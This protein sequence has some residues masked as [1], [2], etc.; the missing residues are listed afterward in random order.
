MIYRTHTTWKYRVL[1]GR[2]AA[3]RNGRRWNDGM[4]YWQIVLV[5]WV[6]TMIY[7]YAL[8]LFP[9]ESALRSVPKRTLTRP[10]WPRKLFH[11]LRYKLYLVLDR[12]FFPNLKIPLVTPLK[13]QYFNVKVKEIFGIWYVCNLYVSDLFPL[14]DKREQSGQNIDA[15]DCPTSTP[16]VPFSHQARHRFAKLTLPSDRK[17]SYFGIGSHSFS[18]LLF[19]SV[20]WSF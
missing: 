1:P 20:T 18:N 15:L 14:T 6:H 3:K 5:L 2:L 9:K 17:S 10:L 16:L 19:H 4:P 13:W 12:I 7:S 11:N 8:I